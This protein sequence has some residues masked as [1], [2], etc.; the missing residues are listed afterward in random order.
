MVRGSPSPL[1]RS[2]AETGRYDP[3][4]KSSTKRP[5]G[6]RLNSTLTARS[7]TA[8]GLG[9]R[10]E[11]K[12]ITGKDLFY[13]VSYCLR[14]LSGQTY[15]WLIHEYDSYTPFETVTRQQ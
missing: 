4:G 10:V 6:E 1:R 13:N 12:E 5:V 8:A 7:E 3:F 11:H 15:K 9:Y 14:L 2:N